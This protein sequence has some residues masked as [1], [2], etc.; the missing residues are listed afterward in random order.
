M[1]EPDT[2]PGILLAMDM[3]QFAL[4]FAAVVI[5]F[6]LVFMRTAKT[7]TLLQELVRLRAV[8]DRLKTIE[9][10]VQTLRSQ[11][12][13][14]AVQESL[15]ALRAIRDRIGQ[16]GEVAVSKVVEIPVPAEAAARPV[17]TVRALVENRLFGMGYH[18]VHILSDLPERHSPDEFSVL[19]EC[20]RDEVAFKG[21]LVVKN[22]AVLDVQL[23]SVLQMFP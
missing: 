11:L 10:V 6:L 9:Q 21:H 8:E 13:I 16:L 4:F 12:P 14:A 19:V 1:Q 3:L 15:E 17:E 20:Q 7:L 5:G 22:G 18:R 23:S 2:L